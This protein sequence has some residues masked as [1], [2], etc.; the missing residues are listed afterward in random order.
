[1]VPK[2]ER[3]PPGRA[4]PAGCWATPCSRDSITKAPSPAPGLPTPVTQTTA[5]RKDKE[6]SEELN[7]QLESGR[8]C[9]LGASPLL[10]PA[11]LACP[12]PV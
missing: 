10:T 11:D 5:E 9:L 4:P 2:T 3:L 7:I 6:L 8:F 12:H 1:M